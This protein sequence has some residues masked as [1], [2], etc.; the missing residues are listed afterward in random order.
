MVRLFQ[1][2]YI[3]RGKDV[4]WT[5]Q[6]TFIMKRGDY[7]EIINKITEIL[8]DIIDRG[9]KL[10]KVISS[11]IVENLDETPIKVDVKIIKENEELYQGILVRINYLEA[12]IK[13]P[14]DDGYA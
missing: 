3:V 10:V 7:I 11:Q 8:N 1:M 4:E 13:K 14:G 6:R 9:L 2:V 12:L 5:E